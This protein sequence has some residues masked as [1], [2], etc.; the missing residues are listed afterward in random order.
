MILPPFLHTSDIDRQYISQDFDGIVL[1][2]PSVLIGQERSRFR[3][4]VYQ[5]LMDYMTE[6]FMRLHYSKQVEGQI[7]VANKS[8]ETEQCVNDTKVTDNDTV[9]QDDACQ[10]DEKN[11]NGC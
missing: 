11:K 3:A 9:M 8:L 4:R 1:P 10:H 2:L 5:K 7:T 6:E